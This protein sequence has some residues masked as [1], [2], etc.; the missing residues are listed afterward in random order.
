MK[1]Y[2][3]FCFVRRRCLE[4]EDCTVSLNDFR[5]H[6]L[7]QLAIYNVPTHR[8]DNGRPRRCMTY[9]T[10]LHTEECT[11]LEGCV[12]DINLR[13]HG[14]EFPR[15]SR[16]TIEDVDTDVDE[17]LKLSDDEDDDELRQPEE[18]EVG[19]IFESVQRTDHSQRASKR[20]K[21]E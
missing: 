20:R 1:V 19:G 17:D 11:D 2:E 3:Q 6:D 8:I 10:L 16:R 21:A 13:V 9:D 7:K 18:E 14:P 12:F 4:I 5:L 15:S